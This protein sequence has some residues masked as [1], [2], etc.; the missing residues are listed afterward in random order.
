[1]L[2][3][4]RSEREPFESPFMV[5]HPASVLSVAAWVFLLT[6]ILCMSADS[7]RIEFFESRIRP[8]L[9]Q[10]CYQCHNSEGTAEGGLVLDHRDGLLEGGDRGPSIVPGDPAQSLLIQAIRHEDDDLKM[11]S[12][13]PK[14][15]QA[16]VRDFEQWIRV[17]APDPRDRP[18]TDTELATDTDWSA[19]MQRRK[20]WWS[21]QPIRRSEPPVIEK[22][23]HPIDRFIRARLAK[24]GLESSAAAE[25]RILLR[26][27]TFALTGLPPTEDQMREWMQRHD[28]SGAIDETVEQLL[29][30]PHFGERWA[31]HWMDWIRYAESHGSEGDPRI[32]NAHLYRDYLIRAL[33]EDIPYDQ[34]VREH[35]AGDLLPDPRIN[36]ELGINE[37]LVGTAHWRMVFHGFAPTDALDEKV[38]FTDDQVN[39]FSKAFLGLTVSCA[40]C[41]DHKFDAISQAD[42]YALFG[43]LSSTR[44]GRKAIDLPA[45]QATNLSHLAELKPKIRTAIADAWIRS[46][47]DLPHRLLR[48]R[49]LWRNAAKSSVMHLMRQMESVAE[50]PQ[51]FANA[52]QK[53]VDA[54]QVVQDSMNAF[55]DADYPFRA[56]LSRWYRE[57]LGLDEQPSP[58]GAFSIQPNGD[59]ALLG[60]YPAGAYSHLISQK[61][62]ARLTSPDFHLRG[63]NDLWL[64]VTGS[65]SAMARY[66][67][68]NYPRNGTV[69]PVKEFKRDDGKSEWEWLRFNVDYW[70]GDDVHIELTAARDAPLLTRQSDRS[71]FG[72]RDAVL[73]PHGEAPPMEPRD[74][75]QP[76]LDAASE[77][78]PRSLEDLAQI[79]AGALKAAAVAW[80]QG[81]LDDDTASF[82]NRCLHDGLVPNDLNSLAAAKPL[83]ERYRELENAIPVPTRVPTLA[84]W[85]AEDQPLLDRG[86]HKK[87]LEPVRRRFLE[88][89]D[90]TPYATQ[91]SGRL[92]LAED[93]LRA[94]NPMTRRVIVN[95]VWHHLFG[96]G[97][98][99]STDNFGR[100]GE[101][102]SHPELLDYLA[103]RFADDGWSIKRLIRLIVTSETWQQA[104]VP[105]PTA[106]GRI[107]AADPENQLLSYFNLQRLDAESIR[108]SMLA[109]AGN[110]D[111]KL[112]GP[113]VD[114]RSNRRSV[115]VRVL[116]NRLDPFLTT[117]D[118]PVPFATTGRRNATIVPAQSLAMLNDPFVLNMAQSVALSVGDTDEPVRAIW[119]RLL[120]RDPNLTEQTQ[121]SALI[122]SLQKIYT[123]IRRQRAEVETQIA[124][125]RAEMKA[126]YDATRSQLQ[127]T[128]VQRTQVVA[129]DSGQ[130][131]SDAGILAE[132]SPAQIDRV[133]ALNDVIGALE[134]KLES[135]GEEAPPNQAYADFALS[136]FNMKEFIY[137]R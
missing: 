36:G 35:V 42:Y 89:I 1:M 15:D 68:Q 126:I 24:S 4:K 106:S 84:E 134:A 43:I 53:G 102:P 132:M 19:I 64:R 96:R 12:S 33:N 34:L 99:S 50:D 26:R 129:A 40:R 122:A 127:Q 71:W 88:A 69:Y 135:W 25:P 55:Q 44:P 9:A 63:K 47:N 86:N 95:R 82:L 121:S 103:T 76:I 38:R 120:G 32:D 92:E 78:P 14:L 131:A 39:V 48:D 73:V 77:S 105:S 130:G 117:F 60:I 23:D 28:R 7:E 2:E 72:I 125:S 21:F 87:P 79:Y 62:P 30:S 54:W 110:L 37:S 17:G 13:G 136:I 101:K 123:R 91:L 133:E 97:I 5:G 18:P 108:D 51:A 45:K 74:F 66:V 11:P 10:D 80:K 20:R 3:A 137:V 90:A 128:P 119:R 75:L 16:I 70:D 56:D 111:P 57:G 49:D 85:R 104:S 93:L 94:D 114:G 61:H 58:P 98:V 22:V 27:L 100:M 113:P 118:A 67:V 59:L 124:A 41:H 112:Y 109:T 29:G 115:Y 6:P 65:G 31:R 52:W 81:K 107:D 8:I 46:S 116:R 83:V